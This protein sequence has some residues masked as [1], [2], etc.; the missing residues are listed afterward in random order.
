LDIGC[1]GG[2]FLKTAQNDGWNVE[3]IEPAR[4]ACKYAKETYGFDITNGELKDGKFQ[5]N[6]FNVVTLCDVIYL[7]QDPMAELSETN[8]ILKAGGMIALRII[9]YNPTFL[10][11]WKMMIGMFR[12]NED[13]LYVFSSNT[14]RQYLEKTGFKDIEVFNAI[15]T[16][17]PEGSLYAN[18]LRKTIYIV[19]QAVYFLS[20]GKLVLGS[21]IEVFA[22]KREN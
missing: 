13:W 5:S 21:C 3:G 4:S 22:R 6:S 19:A 15:P 18:L 20:M 7:M 9:S 10:P 16:E 8:R 12:V 17:R 11:L 1:G 2:G 14:V